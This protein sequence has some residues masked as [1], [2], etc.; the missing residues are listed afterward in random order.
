M[1]SP[2]R[3]ILLGLG[4]S[5]E[6]LRAAGVTEAELDAPA[7]AQLAPHGQEP[8]GIY[9]IVVHQSRSQVDVTSFMDDGPQYVP[10]IVRTSVEFKASL[11]AL[12]AW[13]VAIVDGGPVDFCEVI[14]GRRL[15]CRL[16][17]SSVTTSAPVDGEMYATVKASVVGAPVI[18]NLEP[19]APAPPAVPPPLPA[20]RG[21]RGIKLDGALID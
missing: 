11:L 14:G 15:T 3:G 5:L 18:E 17:V 21:R 2:R 4:F 9:D 1:D 19:Q 6:A 13:H 10:G 16:A 20:K 7:H 12:H 8:S